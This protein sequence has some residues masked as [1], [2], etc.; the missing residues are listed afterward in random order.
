MNTIE[1]QELINSLQNELKNK[2]KT[3]KET[4]REINFK[5][6]LVDNKQLL[7]KQKLNFVKVNFL[8]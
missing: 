5:K 6:E 7:L 8:S 3:L 1:K 4:Q 2:L